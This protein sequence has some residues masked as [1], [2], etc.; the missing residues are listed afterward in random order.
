M[1]R[2]IKP[3]KASDRPQQPSFPWFVDVPK[4]PM[5]EAMAVVCIVQAILDNLEDINP[6]SNPNP[7]YLQ[8]L[9][10]IKNHELDRYWKI[11]TSQFMAKLY[12]LTPEEGGAILDA[13]IKARFLDMKVE[14]ALIHVGLAERK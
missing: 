3:R 7:I 9:E 12:N 13:L 2:N 5:N 6:R 10:E 1:A 14:D 4:F 8:A 11:D